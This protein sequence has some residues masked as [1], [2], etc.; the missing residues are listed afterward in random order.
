MDHGSS[1]WESLAVPSTT[2]QPSSNPWTDIHTS[3][4]A[5]SDIPITPITIIPASPTRPRGNSTSVALGNSGTA[6]KLGNSSIGAST[7]S[8]SDVQIAG[9]NLRPRAALRR[10]RSDSS[11]QEDIPTEP[12]DPSSS[13]KPHRRLT[14]GSASDRESR[15]ASN[16]VAGLWSGD[17]VR[18]DTGSDTGKASRK[19][20]S[21]STLSLSESSSLTNRRASSREPPLPPSL[22]Q[23][24]SEWDW[25]DNDKS[26][27]SKA[28]KGKR[29]AN[30][31]LNGTFGFG[32]GTVGKLWEDMENLLNATLAP[33]GEVYHNGNERSG[34]AYLD[35]WGRP[36]AHP[37]KPE[38]ERRGREKSNERGRATSL[39]GP[40]VETDD[41]FT[42]TTP[43]LTK[44]TTDTAKDKSMKNLVSS[45]GMDVIDLTR[46]GEAGAEVFEHIILPTDSLAGVALKYGITVAQLRKCNKMWA[47]D[48]IHLR[49]VLYIPVSSTRPPGGAS[50]AGNGGIKDKELIDISD[51]SPTSS[52]SRGLSRNGLSKPN[53]TTPTPSP[54]KTLSSFTASTSSRYERSEAPSSPPQSIMS[55]P[56]TKRVPLSEL[57]YFPPPTMPSTTIFT[58]NPHPSTISASQI[59]KWEVENGTSATL[60]GTVGSTTGNGLLSS[61]PRIRANSATQSRATSPSRLPQ[62]I[63]N[64]FPSLNDLNITGRASLDSVRSAGGSVPGSGNVSGEEDVELDELVKKSAK[65]GHKELR[66]RV[67]IK[68]RATT[69]AGETGKEEVGKVITEQ[70]SR[71]RG[72]E[73]PLMSPPGSK[74]ATYGWKAPDQ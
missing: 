54:S 56:S 41:V 14:S 68:P 2:S 47:S 6:T 15:Y 59:R 51:S 19:L 11:K 37:P 61:S 52:S 30:N 44:K 21:S 66:K 3:K 64:V 38:D 48:T 22:P 70:L 65:Q 40:L 13:P 71:Q 39:R 60:F 50:G 10:L 69:V 32:L 55:T 20:T 72:M 33:P 53:S 18:T 58:S 42:S 7:S 27:E 4:A 23:H 24:E 17:T 9:N 28:R 35:V 5:F 49:K 57:S 29:R 73:L 62:S 8:L 45:K 25:D 34:H 67:K 16:G 46:D 36:I 74:P 1:I 12:I 31:P 63:F 26:R 43:G